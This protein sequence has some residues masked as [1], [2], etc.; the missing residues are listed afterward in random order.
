MQVSHLTESELAKLFAKPES[1][2]LDFKAR[3]IQPAKLTRTISAFANADGGEILLGVDEQ[4]AAGPKTWAGFESQEAANGVVQ[5]IDS[6][7]P[8]GEGLRMGFLSAD[9]HKGLILHIEV[10]KSRDI[11]RTT[12]G[13]VYLRRGAQNIPVAMTWV[14]ILRSV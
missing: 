2:F 10:F 3:A 7:L 13:D 14:P 11:I 12:S 5:A 8:L 1:H 6:V 4:S 9:H